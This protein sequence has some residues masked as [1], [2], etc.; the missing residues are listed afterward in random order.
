MSTR[1]SMGTPA[2]LGP[3]TL[4][5][6]HAVG[7]SLAIGPIFSAGLLTSLVAAVA[8]Y[9]TPLAVLL[10]S[11]GVLGLGYVISVFAR[12][13]TG[14][15]AVYEYLARGANP[16][17]G[18]FAAGLYFLGALFLGGGGI[19]IAIGYFASAFLQSHVGFVVP[20]WLPAA[21]ILTVVFLLNHYGVRPAIRGVL[22][23]AGASAIPFLVL[24]AAILLKGGAAGD[25]LSVFT[26]AH[27]SWG[28]VFAGILFAVTLFIGFEAAASI[29]EESKAPK[30][31]IPLA[32]M[33]TI[34]I[35]AA[36][37]VLIT[38]AAAV[39]FGYAAIAKGAWANAASPMADLATV[40]VGK[41]L[42]TLID[43]VV[44][45]DMTSV[46]IAIMVTCSRGFFA[47]GRD[48]LLPQWTARTSRHQTPLAGNLITVGWAVLLILWAAVQSWGRG[49]QMPS[50]LQTF[51]VTAAAGSYLVELIYLLL[52]AVALKILYFEYGFSPRGLWRYLLVLMGLATPV[53]AF[54][55]SLSPFPTYPNSLGVW[56]AVGGLFLVAF[57]TTGLLLRTP[58]RISRAAEYALVAPGGEL[59]L[60]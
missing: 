34:G 2:H 26:V 41:W 36:F 51:F 44:I 53:L 6:V 58:E 4:T 21:F 5:L 46:A 30:E 13:Y 16:T 3:R 27:S 40:Y 10:G 39:G 23:L 17:F 45:F 38:Y 48:G 8:G 47:L 14:A 35:S 25:T 12:R 33:A 19:Y 59:E 55:G 37:Y 57:W 28:A 18:V 42:G 49:A 7:Q 54:W 32:V 29:A 22:I 9:S 56:L 24:A 43:L 1:T 60:E 15:G 31:S 20:P 52:A 50:E 11:I